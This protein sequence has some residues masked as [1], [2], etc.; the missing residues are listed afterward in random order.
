MENVYSQI[1]EF[2]CKHCHRCCG[3]II[4]FKPEEI[5]IRGYIKNH[6][7]EYIVWSTEQ[8]KNN[9][10]CCPYL[11]NDRCI[12][13]PVRPIVCRLQ[14]NVSDMPCEYNTK[15]IMSKNQ[16]DRIKKEFEKLLQ[17]T[18]GKNVF[19]GTRKYQY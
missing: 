9:D 14:G 19:Y 5:F 11:K 13:Y 1:P 6:D 12:I 2:E 17:E 3:P 10:M 18:D 4:W 16:L 7:V 8:F 15:K